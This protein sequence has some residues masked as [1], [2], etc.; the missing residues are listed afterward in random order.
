MRLPTPDEVDAPAAKPEAPEVYNAHIERQEP[1]HTATG[2]CLEEILDQQS[3]EQPDAWVLGEELGA[4]P[5]IFACIKRA[6]L[7]ATP[8]ELERLATELRHAQTSI[9]L[10]SASKEILA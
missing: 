1:A 7:A 3:G 4:C 10:I 2:P 6:A 8:G 9:A 5:W